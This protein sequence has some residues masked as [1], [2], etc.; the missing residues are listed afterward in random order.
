MSDRVD[1]VDAWQCC[2]CGSLHT[3][4]SLAEQCAMKCEW[5]EL[6]GKIAVEHENN[7]KLERAERLEV[8]KEEFKRLKE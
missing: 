1:K 2:Y 8:L 4:L 3:H 5:Y 6:A 7:K